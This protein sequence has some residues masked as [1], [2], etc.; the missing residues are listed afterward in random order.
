MRTLSN[1]GGGFMGWY[2]VRSAPGAERLVLDSVSAV[3]SLGAFLPFLK[4]S[5]GKMVPL[6]TRY[7][8][9]LSPDLDGL[10]PVHRTRGVTEIVG[11][12]MR[13]PTVRRGL[14]ESLMAIQQERGGF[15]VDEMP[16]V[17]ERSALVAGQQVEIVSGMY[18]GAVTTLLQARGNTGRLMLALF[19][20]ETPVTVRLDQLRAA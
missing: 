6:F 9:V 12:P 1:I 8:F 11:P 2:A 16:V 20:R 13:Q 3:S 7:L 14:V 19:G 18:A 4:T 15:V 17:V 10:A 5:V